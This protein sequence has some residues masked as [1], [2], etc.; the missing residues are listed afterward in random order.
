MK[1]KN[2]LLKCLENKQKHIFFLPQQNIYNV[3]DIIRN[4]LTYQESGK[5]DPLSKEETNNWNQPW[6][7]PDIETDRTLKQL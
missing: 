4:S 6:Y 7:D 5:C 2:Q 3:W 1:Y